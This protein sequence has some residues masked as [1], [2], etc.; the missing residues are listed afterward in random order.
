M[1]FVLKQPQGFAMFSLRMAAYL[2]VAPTIMGI[3]V[4]ALLTADLF[5][6]QYISIA[7]VV[8][9]ILGV[10]AALLL[11]SKLNHLIKT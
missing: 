5:S 7:A 3:L 6:A 11:A 9:A 4:V 8:G 2:L 1:L 10:P